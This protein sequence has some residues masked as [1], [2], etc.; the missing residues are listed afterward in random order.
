MDLCIEVR[1]EELTGVEN[2]VRE[3][4][5]KILTATTNSWSFVDEALAL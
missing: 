1:V 5:M 4:G 2:H 3:S